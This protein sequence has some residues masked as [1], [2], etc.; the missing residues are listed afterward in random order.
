MDDFVI[1]SW[2]LEKF[3]K[4]KA[5]LASAGVARTVSETLDLHYG[6]KA[7]S[8]SFVGFFQEVH[9]TPEEVAKICQELDKAFD[10]IGLSN[11]ERV[12]FHVFPCG[13]KVM[14]PESIIVVSRG[15]DVNDPL[16]LDVRRKI[17]PT[18]E[19]QR[20]MAGNNALAQKKLRANVDPEFK[21]IGMD[22][23]ETSTITG[24][25]K[26]SFDR[27]P[28]EM[29][30]ARREAS[31][32]NSQFEAQKSN[33]PE[34]RATERAFRMILRPKS[35]MNIKNPDTVLPKDENY[36]I[37]PYKSDYFR[38]AVLVNVQPRG[39]D[40]MVRIASAHAPGPNTSEKDKNILDAYKGVA[41]GAK[42]D[43]MVADLN[44]RK[45]T[46]DDHFV[47][48][49]HLQG[50]GTTTGRNNWEKF[51][52]NTWDRILQWKKSS[53][54]P[55]VGEPKKGGLYP[56][57]KE[58]M[59]RVSDHG[60]I[61]LRVTDTDPKVK[62]LA[63]FNNIYQNPISESSIGGMDGKNRKI[64]LSERDVDPRDK[65]DDNFFDFN[66]GNLKKIPIEKSFESSFDQK[67]SEMV[68]V[69]KFGSNESAEEWAGN[70]N[71][72]FGPI[73]TNSAFKKSPFSNPSKLGGLLSNPF[74]GKI[75]PKEKPEITEMQE[76]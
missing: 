44:V 20:K 46:Q 57:N 60:L 22:G 24:F 75:Q 71:K 13:G 18:I 21:Q 17:D 40:Q 76:E 47:D 35:S 23:K 65:D 25:A 8:G 2:N 32:I 36:F 33:P 55:I 38:N 49:S 1:L 10:A 73:D 27:D 26:K 5:K 28:E 74:S 66:P 64:K 41:S 39:S 56:V 6:D 3:N 37:H 11:A 15:L 62:T 29:E 48:L 61:H 58:K 52:K 16:E 72:F 34:T 12:N 19:I 68:R 7:A 42:A 51:G 14:P 70:S 9:G 59:A 30:K 50:S 63:E 31:E 45:N 69:P 53:L 43:F 4:G 54:H 67:K